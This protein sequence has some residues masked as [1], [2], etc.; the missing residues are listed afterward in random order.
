MMFL[1][2]IVTF[3]VTYAAIVVPSQDLA[4][5]KQTYAKAVELESKG[6][7]PAA[8]ALLW[9]AAGLAPRDPDIQDALGEALERIGA[10]DAAI[11]AYRAALQDSPQSRKA[12]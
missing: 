10:L 8:L 1:T 12:S 9:E 11:A 7:H 5:A 6:N 3:A 2:T 4:R